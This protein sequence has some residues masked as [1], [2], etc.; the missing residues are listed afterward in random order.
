[1]LLKNISGQGIY[2]YAYNVTGSAVDTGDAANIT[3]KFSLDGGAEASFGTTNPTEIGGG[4]Y[5]QPLAQAETNGNAYN[6]RWSSTT[7]GVVITPSIGF[8]SG[9]NLPTAAP[10]ASGGLITFGT[11]AGQVTTDGT[12]RVLVAGPVKKNTALNNFTFFMVQSLDHAS[13]ATGLTV[14]VQVSLDGAAFGASANSPA[15]EIGGGW[16]K[17]NLASADLNGNVVALQFAAA[18]ADTVPATILTQS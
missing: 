10:N 12:G 1:M 8:T 18:G 16:Y 2:L 17:I 7:S 15:A 13:P 5:W 11:G 3:G 9:A 6:Y 4:C 14:A